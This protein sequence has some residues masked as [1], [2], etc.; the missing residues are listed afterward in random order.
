MVRKRRGNEW[1]LLITLS[2]ILLCIVTL[3]E[4]FLDIVFAG[5][6]GN[7]IVIL[8]SFIALGLGLGAL[9][10]SIMSSKTPK[11]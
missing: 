7:R 11:F 2:L 4:R 9:Y 8:L 1:G 6:T 3:I 10:L 5:Y